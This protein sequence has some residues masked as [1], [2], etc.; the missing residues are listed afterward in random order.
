[1][2]TQ[3]ERS[4][5]YEVADRCCEQDEGMKSRLARARAACMR[6]EQGVRRCEIDW[7]KEYVV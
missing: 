6:C 3:S 1:M 7:P 4:S 2:E 5:C